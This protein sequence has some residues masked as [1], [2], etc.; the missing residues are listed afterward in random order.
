MEGYV[1]PGESKTLDLI[2]DPLTY[3]RGIHEANLLID[4]W[5][6]NHQLEPKAIPLTFC[7]DTTTSVEWTEAQRPE[8]ITLLQNY[9]NPF[10][11]LTIVRFCVHGSQSTV[12][13]TSHVSLGIYNILGQLV[14]TLKDEEMMPGNYQVV[15]DGKDDKGKELASGIYF[16][17]LAAGSCQDVRKMVLVK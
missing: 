5:D 16:C 15:W 14:R 4:S 11:P 9:P 8:K 2:F 12:H 6:K 13:S 10:N 7:I 17:K 1:Q 3:P